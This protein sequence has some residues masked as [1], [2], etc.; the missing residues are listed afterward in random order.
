MDREFYYQHL[1]SV[2]DTV[3][4]FHNCHYVKE[5]FEIMNQ[6]LKKSRKSVKRTLGIINMIRRAIKLE[7]EDEKKNKVASS[8]AKKEEPAQLQEGYETELE[9]GET[10]NPSLKSFTSQAGISGFAHEWCK[11]P[12][13]VIVPV[14]TQ[15]R[16]EAEKVVSFLMKIGEKEELPLMLQGLGDKVKIYLA[17]GVGNDKYKLE[18]TTAERLMN[19]ESAGLENPE[20]ENCLSVQIG[21]EEFPYPDSENPICT[22]GS[23]KIAND[24]E[25]VLIS[26]FTEKEEVYVLVLKKCNLEG[27]TLAGLC[28]QIQEFCFE[29][30]VPSDLG[31]MFVKIHSTIGEPFIQGIISTSSPDV[32]KIVD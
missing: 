31:E 12:F 1:Q 21:D 2:F 23:I 25:Y 17:T 30:S 9:F 8:Q 28:E 4:D 14:E 22:F 10:E 19:P 13:L 11:S 26:Q 20:T 7:K 15:D 27:Q 32:L 29:D 5:K 3:N 24:G 16:A 6:N 18:C